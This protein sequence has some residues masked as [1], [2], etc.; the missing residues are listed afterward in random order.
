MTMT[1]ESWSTW[2]KSCHCSNLSTKNPI[3]TGLVWS[4]DFR[5]KRPATNRSATSMAPFRLLNCYRHFG[6]ACNSH[7]QDLDYSDHEGGAWNSSETLKI[8]YHSSRTH[9]THTTC[10][11]DI[12]VSPKVT[13]YTH[14]IHT[15]SSP[16]EQLV[17][18]TL[19]SIVKVSPFSYW[20]IHISEIQ[21]IASTLIIPG[22]K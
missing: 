17:E 5:G 15:E 20:H 13:C 18:S 3:G 22:V 1:A 19:Y 9:D 2:R 4:P 10:I 6:R 7:L 8:A 11:L 14:H 12:P 16:K 21:I